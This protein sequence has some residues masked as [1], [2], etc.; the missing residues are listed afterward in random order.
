MTN[1][2]TPDKPPELTQRQQVEWEHIVF[3]CTGR[4]RS[5]VD[6]GNEI[7]AAVIRAVD[8]RLRWLEQQVKETRDDYMG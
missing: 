5:G 2:D 7:N 1:L 8:A 3:R 4:I 6:V